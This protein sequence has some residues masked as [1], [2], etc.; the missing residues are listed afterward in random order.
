[1]KR[2]PG[3]GMG[4]AFLSAWPVLASG[5]QPEPDDVSATIR[6]ADVRFWQA[7][8][9]CD[10]TAQ[11]QFL[12]ED[13]EFYHDK[14]GITLGAEALMATIKANLC[15][16][17]SRLRRAAVDGTVQVFPLRSQGVVYGAILSGEHLFYLREKG[18]PERLDGQARFTHLWLLRDG[19]WRMARILSYDHGPAKAAGQ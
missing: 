10:T 12:A 9:T 19:T 8:N 2:L 17:G 7:Y 14:G 6:S 3:L 1:M 16:E 5:P 18:K 13:V 4:L 11:R 15:S